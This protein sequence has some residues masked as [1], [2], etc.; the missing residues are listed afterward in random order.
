M[1]SSHV[2]SV[3]GF[4][5]IDLTFVITVF[6]VGQEKQEAL[7]KMVNLSSLAV[8]HVSLV[9]SHALLSQK[10]V[11]GCIMGMCMG[12]QIKDIYPLQNSTH[13]FVLLVLRSRSQGL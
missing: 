11:R 6:R 8:V 10:I 3:V 5:R 1:D 9:I 4:M 12:T 7:M 13:F 2:E